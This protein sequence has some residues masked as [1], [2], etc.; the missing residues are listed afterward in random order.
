MQLH[1]IKF[2]VGVKPISTTQVDWSICT[3]V[4]S[5]QHQPTSIRHSEY[6]ISTCMIVDQAQSTA[7]SPDRSTNHTVEPQTCKL[8]PK[9]TPNFFST[10]P[11]SIDFEPCT[12]DHQYMQSNLASD[13]QQSKWSCSYRYDLELPCIDET[14]SWS[15]STD[16]DW[17]MQPS[18]ASPSQHRSTTENRSWW[19][20]VGVI[21]GFDL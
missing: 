20:E 9:P 12:V 16:L 8:N 5:I 21:L 3:M 6:S 13:D 4:V 19:I 17:S 10:H 15:A 2:E 18:T 11:S 1:S 7:E 14:Y